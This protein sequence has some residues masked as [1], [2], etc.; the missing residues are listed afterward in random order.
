KHE[1]NDGDEQKGGKYL[2]HF[3]FLSFFTV[4]KDHGKQDDAMNQSGESSDSDIVLSETVDEIFEL[5]LNGIER[6]KK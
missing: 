1:R 3:D 6:I 4:R 5:N 2:N